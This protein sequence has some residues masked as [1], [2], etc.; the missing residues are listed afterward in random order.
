MKFISGWSSKPEAELAFW[1]RQR[2]VSCAETRRAQATTP[3]VLETCYRREAVH[4]IPAD[5]REWYREALVAE[6]SYGAVTSAVIGTGAGALP[7]DISSR[8]H[9]LR[10]L[11][12]EVY[13]IWDAGR[14]SICRESPGRTIPGVLRNL[15]RSRGR[16]VTYRLTGSTRSSTPGG[17]IRP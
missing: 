13:E 7:R 4:R 8:E 1:Q 3:G 2:C 16:G 9:F 6:F 17:E 12:A 15:R 10:F 14:L 11:H 5:V